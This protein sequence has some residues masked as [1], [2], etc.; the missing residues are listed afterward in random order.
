MHA[1]LASTS[2]VVFY[3][4]FFQILF[5][6]VPSFFSFSFILNSKWN[7]ALRLWL[8]ASYIFGLG[9][10]LQLNQVFKFNIMLAF[11]IDSSI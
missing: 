7:A 3:Q 11:I 9:Q 1:C 5:I 2:I 4:R 10:M 6:Y 8:D